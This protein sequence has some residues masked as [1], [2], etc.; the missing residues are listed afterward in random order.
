[1]GEAR[2]RD[3][4]A[5]QA[6]AREAPQAPA[7][8]RSRDKAAESQWLREAGRPPDA[9]RSARPRRPPGRAPSVVVCDEGE[10]DDVFTLLGR[11][12]QTPLRVR[13]SQ[14][15]GLLDW[16]RPTRLFVTT[17]RVALAHPLA[18][19]H[20]AREV[21]SIAV[22]DSDAHT[23]CTAMLR[24]GFRYV[25][26]RPV[27]PGSLRLLLLQVLYTGR[28][29]RVVARFPFG[30]E[31]R[32]RRGLRRGTCVMTEIS[33]H[34]CRLLSAVRFPLGSRL[35]LRLPAALAGAR[36]LR[37][38]GRVV[39]RDRSGE[40]EVPDTPIAVRFEEL[41]SRAV[42]HLD[43]LLAERS[44]GPAALRGAAAQAAGVAAQP[45]ERSGFGSRVEQAEPAPEPAAAAPDLDRRRRPRAAFRH[46]VVS[47]DGDSRQVQHVL[48]GTDL[49]LRGLSVEPHPLLRIGD[50][51]KLALYDADRAQPLVLDARVERADGRRGCALIFEDVP[52]EAASQ[53]E[54][55]VAQLPLVSALSADDD[56]PQAVVL[57][58]ILGLTG[59]SEG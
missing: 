47:L 5:P 20:G 55:M 43:A 59:R 22:A 31:V 51:L 50:R 15:E 34:G 52:A 45:R 14:L 12:D 2:D 58:Q 30:A 28:E 19:V 38:T 56:K 9:D 3:R 54:A 27:H 17:V 10:L 46:E 42:A 21:V 41:S 49:S 8:P 33:A 32:W 4:E 53:L 1:M 29:H 57:G 25:V 39:R 13:P 6:P 40:D 7:T 44:S 24:R 16:E 18:K 23:L 11:L 36:D 37:L 48:V 35:R 26:R